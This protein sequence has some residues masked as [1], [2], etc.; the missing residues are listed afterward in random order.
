VI[1]LTYPFQFSQLPKQ[2]LAIGDFDGVHLGHQKV[3]GDALHIAR[4]NHVP[5][6]IMT[7]DPHPRE[8]LGQDKYEYLLTPLSQ[9]IE[10]IEQLGVDYLYI[11]HFTEQ[12]ATFSADFFIEQVLNNMNLHTVVIGFDFKFGHRGMGNV[13]FL[14]NYQN[15]HF[16]VH[17]VQPHLELEE[18]VSSTRIRGLLEKGYI[19]E[20]PQLLGRFYDLLGIVEHGDGRGRTIGFPTA[21]LALDGSYILPKLGVYAVRVFVRNKKHLG[22]VNIGVR[23]T[24]RVEPT[25]TNIEVHLLDF[26]ED[27]YNE[28]MRIELMGFIRPEQ[29]FNDVDSLVNQIH[30]DINQVKKRFAL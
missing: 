27:L 5:V 7:F 26:N 23:P 11:V 14:Q 12:F 10:L 19:E 6:G 22:I 17:V 28:Q 25:K 3:I 30:I 29:K 18:K 21:N 4:N 15:K 1:Q 8:I 20:I 9:K 16:A 24:F 13:V 2:V